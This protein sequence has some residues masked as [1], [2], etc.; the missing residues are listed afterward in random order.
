VATQLGR[1]CSFQLII[2]ALFTDWQVWPAMDRVIGKL[3][4]D[5]DI[6]GIDIQYWVIA[7][8]AVFALWAAYEIAAA[9]IK[10]RK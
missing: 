3:L 10:K 7:F 6:F 1:L 9:Q 8:G 2:F 4:T 5:A